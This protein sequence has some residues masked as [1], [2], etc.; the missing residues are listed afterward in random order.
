MQE[1]TGRDI[2][3]QGHRQQTTTKD[4]SI[5]AGPSFRGGPLGQN[6][7]A[8][9]Q[10]R[11]EESAHADHRS[12]ATGKEAS[13]TQGR[14]FGGA[15]VDVTEVQLES[16]DGLRSSHAAHTSA[17]PTSMHQGFMDEKGKRKQV[18][19]GYGMRAQGARSHAFGTTAKKKTPTKAQFAIREEKAG[20]AAPAA[21]RN[22]LHALKGLPLSTPGYAL[23]PSLKESKKGIEHWVGLHQERSR[24]L[25]GQLDAAATPIAVLASCYAGML[26]ATTYSMIVETSKSQIAGMKQNLS[27]MCQLLHQ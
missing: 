18:Q 11:F 4:P 10:A 24:L 12:G 22:I 13:D 9:L 19:A 1:Q 6:V 8:N 16:C 17:V 23:Q 25:T 15:A 7:I 3:E 14:H 27:S 21:A 5:V 20:S 26:R 2:P